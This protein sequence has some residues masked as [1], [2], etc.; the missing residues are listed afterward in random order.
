[1]F[2]AR[3]V[4]LYV[5]VL[6]AASCLVAGAYL[7]FDWADYGL[8]S[9]CGN[10]IRRAPWTGPCSE[11]MWHRVFAVI[12]LVILASLMLLVGVVGWLRRDKGVAS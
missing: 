4:R 11:I 9:T 6:V 10:F 8:D 1:M 3:G 5:S 12:G 7:A 2:V